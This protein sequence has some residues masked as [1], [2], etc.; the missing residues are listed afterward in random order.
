MFR[1]NGHP[2]A[3]SHHNGLSRK[4]PLS[5]S[6]P[7]EI[8]TNHRM[9]TL[10]FLTLCHGWS[11]LIFV[12]QPEV[13]LKTL[14]STSMLKSSHSVSKS[15]SAWAL[16]RKKNLMSSSSSCFYWISGC[17]SGCDETLGWCGDVHARVGLTELSRQWVYE[18]FVRTIDR[19]VENKIKKV[20]NSN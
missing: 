7:E 20:Q 12:I 15:M 2:S 11:I 19:K 1:R 3:F 8:S 4:Y 5:L 16:F 14:I 9:R 18:V 10:L 6:S 13:W 17:S